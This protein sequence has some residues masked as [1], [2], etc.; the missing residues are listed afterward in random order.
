MKKYVLLIG[1]ALIIALNLNAGPM[2]IP[3]QLEEGRMVVKIDDQTCEITTT[4][5]TIV[6]VRRDR[7][8][9]QTEKDHIPDRIAELEEQIAKLNERAAE[10]DKILEVFE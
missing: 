7:A 2:P 3:I 6:V 10:I 9:L 4:K 5:T 8:E 1:I